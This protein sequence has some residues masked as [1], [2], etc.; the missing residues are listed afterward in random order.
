MQIR[1]EGR[2]MK[3]TDAIREHVNK[4]ISHLDKYFDGITGIHVILSVEDT[5]Q[6]S[7]ISEIVCAVVRGQPLVATAAHADMYMAVDESVHKMREHLKKFKSKMRS[8]KRESARFASPKA[9]LGIPNVEVLE[10]DEGQ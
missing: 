1:I 3:V 2:H 7:Q 5:R 8:R 10:E 6:K 9:G 4:K